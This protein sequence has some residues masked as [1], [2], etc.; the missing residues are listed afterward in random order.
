M[1]VCCLPR[2][3]LN[4]RIHTVVLESDAQSTQSL[5]SQQATT[6]PGYV[7]SQCNHTSATSDEI[8]SDSLFF[9]SR[10]ETQFG[11]PDSV[12]DGSDDGEETFCIHGDR[13]EG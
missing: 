5:P 13:R 2:V 7:A 4:A 11:T 12:K 9:E 8:S 1:K 3:I 6:Q 10:R